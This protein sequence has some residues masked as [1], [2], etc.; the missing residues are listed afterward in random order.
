M[1]ASDARDRPQ[2]DDLPFLGGVV[3]LLQ[4]P[5]PH[6]ACR[7]LF[8]LV[9]V[10]RGQGTVDYPTIDGPYRFEQQ[11]TISHDGRPFL[12]H[13]TRSRLIDDGGHVVRLAARETGWWRPQP[14]GGIELLLAH[15]TGLLELFSGTTNSQSSWE[16]ATETVVR[17]ASAKEV[18]A[19]RRRY[20]IDADGELSYVEE[21]AMVG[22]P[23]TA[24]VW[25]RL[26][27]VGG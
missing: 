7:A 12:L 20:D 8:P 21:R 4:E 13:E 15:C 9:G 3:N 19:A 23:M 16:L 10:W 24:H 1:P 26:H 18:N 25:A 6:D 5:K 22:Q 2:P 17:S 11:I 27:R 14:D